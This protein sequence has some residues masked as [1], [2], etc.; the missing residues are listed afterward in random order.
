M[1]TY[2]FDA[3][4]ASSF[5]E[6]GTL[7]IKD[8]DESVIRFAGGIPSVLF[9][10]P[11]S[12]SP[13]SAP[14]AGFEI[15]FWDPK[16]FAC[17]HSKA[18]G[19]NL[20]N[21]SA[22][23]VLGSLNFT[24]S[25]LFR[26]REL[27]LHFSVS[28]GS[29]ESNVSKALLPLFRDWK[30]FLEQNY[31]KRESKRERER[32]SPALEK[33]LDDLNGILEQIPEPISETSTS[34]TSTTSPS[35]S[36]SSSLRLL[37]SGYGRNDRNDRSGRTQHEE[38]KSAKDVDT[39]R[40][41]LEQL[42]AAARDF[43]FSPKEFTRLVFVTPFFDKPGSPKER[44]AFWRFRRKDAFPGI[45][46]V[47]G[48][49][50]I[51]LNDWNAQVFEGFEEGNGRKFLRYAIPSLIDAG[52]AERLC[53]GSTERRDDSEYTKE[54]SSR[55]S[56]ASVSAENHLGAVRQLHAKALLLLN[57]KDEGLL[58]VGSANFTGKA[59]LGANMELG[60][61]GR[62]AGIS[63]PEAWVN[64]LLGVKCSGPSSGSMNAQGDM[65][66]DAEDMEDEA[67]ADDPSMIPF[68]LGLKSIWLE[69]VDGVGGD[70]RSG[71][72][73]NGGEIP[74]LAGRFVFSFERG[75]DVTE[76]EFRWGEKT[77]PLKPLSEGFE[78]DADEERWT[79]GV[80]GAEDVKKILQT[81][82]T[83]GW[84]RRGTTLSAAVPFNVREEFAAGAEIL[85]AVEP[86]N[87]F[88]YLSAQ[89]AR[90]S[91]SRYCRCEADSDA[92][93]SDERNAS[94]EEDEDGFEAM[95]EEKFEEEAQ[96]RRAEND[97]VRM[98][99]W[100]K[101]F[102]DFERAAGGIDGQFANAAN[103][104]DLA[105]AF[106]TA[107]LLWTHRE[108][109][110]QAKLFIAGESLMLARR[111]SKALEET[112]KGDKAWECA[113]GKLE[114]AFSIALRKIEASGR[115]SADRVV[116]EA[117]K[118]LVQSSGSIDCADKNVTQE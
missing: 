85:C 46:E 21:G 25:G 118:T 107:A 98:Q 7:E 60:V 104:S 109:E 112:G 113:A 47:M 14:P 37:C 78:D 24:E 64:G 10:D 44:K 5:A 115:G 13:S 6:K 82:R 117:F 49:S 89:T 96:S 61:V 53:R 54:G 1:L 93:F 97:V 84:R 72:G 36:T 26:N 77:I 94:S 86:E 101:G 42:V 62:V 17:H 111:I 39:G 69:G 38:K 35:S 71:D 75:R 29:N 52:E 40:S 116:L 41:G 67:A 55:A 73:S 102:A 3:W 92:E 56:G 8:A 19:F 83:L 70:E 90:K 80:I 81:G 88:K 30:R 15:N 79:S 91:V 50:A 108:A 31:A 74:I 22:H 18:Y 95:F 106:T 114:A 23:L 58:Y 105:A 99:N 87:W 66:V 57:E 100:I 45:R 65:P 12:G 110:P 32:K 68:P 28:K 16:G 27:L 34:G 103:R 33:Y 51:Q 11:S 20:E 4:L 59:W 76:N 43:G 2:N 63:D 48:F 9:Y